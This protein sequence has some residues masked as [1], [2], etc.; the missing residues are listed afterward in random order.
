IN[1]ELRRQVRSQ[2][3]REAEPSL[4]IIDSQSV[5]TAQKGA[6]KRVSMALQKT[7]FLSSMVVRRLSFGL[8]GE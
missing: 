2:A 5:K 8:A 7:D 6:I 3:G 1:D 4:G